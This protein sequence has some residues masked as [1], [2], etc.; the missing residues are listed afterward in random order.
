MTKTGNL[1]F[2]LAFLFSSFA[3]AA[4]TAL[5]SN[6]DRKNVALG[7]VFTLTLTV[8]SD[9]DD[10]QDPRI[11]ELDGFELVDQSRNQASSRMLTQ[12]PQG[13]QFQQQ[14]LKNYYYRLRATKMG[15]LSLPAFE[16]V[17]GG[18][19]F[20]SQP[21]V[22]TVSDGNSNSAQG[23][24]DEMDSAEEELYN[25]ILQQR[26]QLL[27]QMQRPQFAPGNQLDDEDPFGGFARPRGMTD[28]AFRSLPT[29]P[30]EAFFISVEID[31]TEVYEGE[32]VT[33]NWYVYTRGQMETLDRL[34][35]PS[36]KGF[37]KEIIEEVPSI[38]FSEEVVGGI[39]WKKAL[40]AS[41]ALFPI[42]AGTAVIDEYKIKS[43]VRILTQGMGGFLG[44]P[45]EYTKS[46]ARVPIKV[47]PLPVEGRPS[48][49][50][51]AVGQFELHAVVENPTVPVNQPFSLRVRFEGAGNAKLIDLPALN[52]P[53]GL[54]QYDSKSESKFFKN[55]RSFKEFEVL[56]IPRQ[57][58]EVKI[59]GLSVSMFD[60]Q[61]NKYYTKTTEPITL[62]V[63]NNP[64]APV[65]SSARMADTAKAK[66]ATPENRL[67]DPVM[68]W[69]PAKEAS[70]LY[71]PWM[72]GLI[73]GF[74]SL[75]FLYKAQR[76]FGWGRRRRTLKE[77]VQKRY[78]KVE[79]ALAKN[80]YRKVGVEMTNTYYMVLGDIAGTGGASQEITRL[81]DLMPPSVRRD[82][83]ND[84]AKSFEVFQTLSFAPEEVLGK[85]KEPSELKASV[86]QGKKVISSIIAA[87]E[88]K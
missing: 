73:Y 62:N 76:E 8:V 12:T 21:F 4:G 51:G 53:T 84:I 24:M 81:V 7:Q 16:V 36:L 60:P 32:Q 75:S 19:V 79:A 85:L 15:R 54:E 68:S 66:V 33:V 41:H 49:F 22:I 78:K 64:N 31:K 63:V 39:P 88:T 71:R 72:W 35:F 28:A 47:K 17:S 30:N 55:G 56:V 3:T 87:V 44:K 18:K 9:S 46:S 5:Q 61:T 25:Q 42:K 52:L 29:N 69:E 1:L 86:D 2:V 59:P 20:R 40:L 27:Q 80:D 57:E 58:G 6:V 83:G 26:A 11:P 14:Y 34:K 65:G 48:D 43:R 82:Y 45:Y 13:M 38:Q 50:T 70:L 37:W 23:Q 10:S 74:I 77:L 67:P